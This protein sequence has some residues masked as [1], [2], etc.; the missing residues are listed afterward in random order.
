VDYNL[1]FLEKLN[2]PS[3]QNGDFTQNGHT[4]NCYL[5]ICYGRKTI[6]DQPLGQVILSQNEKTSS[7]IIPYFQHKQNAKEILRKISLEQK[8]QLIEN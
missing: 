4:K 7:T 5:T 1:P 2:F 3:I 8:L 6:F